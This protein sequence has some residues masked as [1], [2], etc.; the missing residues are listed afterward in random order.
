M[1]T[2][3]GREKFRNNKTIFG[4]YVVIIESSINIDNID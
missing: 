1:L 3:M 4:V 2:K